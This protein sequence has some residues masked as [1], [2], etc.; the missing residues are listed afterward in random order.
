MTRQVGSTSAAAA[1]ALGA[2]G[3]S[4]AGAGGPHLDSDDD[5]YENEYRHGYGGSEGKA[6]DALGL[7]EATADD[8]TGSITAPAFM[9]Q[10]R[11]AAEAGSAGGGAA[12]SRSGGHGSPAFAM[13]L[14]GADDVYIAVSDFKHTMHACAF[15]DIQLHSCIC[16]GCACSMALLPLFFAYTLRCLLLPV[17]MLFA[18]THPFTAGRVLAAWPLTR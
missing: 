13:G 14:G 9:R 4:A 6:G 3:G 17:L 12:G 2:T 15:R 16:S 1:A 8:S 18:L 11:L 7:G 10:I 5:D